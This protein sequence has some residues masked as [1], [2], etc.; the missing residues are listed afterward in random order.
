MSEKNVEIMRRMTTAFRKDDTVAALTAAGEF[1]DPQLE[2][3]T[4]R[5]GA[6]GL[7]GVYRGLEEVGQFWLDWA[8]AWGSLGEFPDPEIVDAGDQV[9]A[10][11]TRHELRGKGSG[12]ELEMPA[13]GWVATIRDQKVERATLYSTETKPSKPPGCENSPRR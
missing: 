5:L 11:F 10:W 9:F 4:T 3:D 12:I 6:P 2:M 13:Y 8:D 7:A 1:L